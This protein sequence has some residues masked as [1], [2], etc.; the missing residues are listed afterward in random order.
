MIKRPILR[1]AAI[2][3]VIHLVA[4]A[5]SLLFGFSLAMGRFD[6]PGMAPG[7]AEA[8]SSGLA[9]F[10]LQP[11]QAIYSALHAGS[12]ASAMVQWLSLVLNSALWGLVLAAAVMWLR[13]ALRT[14]GAGRKP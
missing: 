8:T 4:A 13:Q 6:S 3:S 5:A 2:F 10:L 12:S 1:L 9:A 14:R 7:H 11:G